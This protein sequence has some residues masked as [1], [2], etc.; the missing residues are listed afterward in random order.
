MQKKDAKNKEKKATRDLSKGKSG[1]NKSN[2]DLNNSYSSTTN[3][4]SSTMK[5][6][7]KEPSS[8]FQYTDNNQESEKPKKL[9]L[10]DDTLAGKFKTAQGSCCS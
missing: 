1:M 2:S 3:T 8:N 6:A 7:S 9:T 10:K 5:Y 4:Y